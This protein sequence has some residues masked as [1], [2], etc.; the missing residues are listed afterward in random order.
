M[1]LPSLNVD[2]KVAFVTGTGSG[3]GRAISIGL[4]QAG[5]DLALTELPDRLDAARETAREIEKLGKRAHVVP[6]DVMK[7]SQIG[8]SVDA[9]LKHFGHLD[10]LVNNAGVNIPKLAVDV[11][12]ADW[13]K[14]MAIDLKGVFFTTQTVAKKALIPQG[15]GKVVNIASQMGV[16]GYK[17]RAAYCSAKAGVVNLSRV[18]AF[19]WAKHKITVN[20]VAP[21]FI[22]TPLTRPMFE[23]KEFY[24]DVI[25][26]I[27]MGR[28][29]TPED[30]VGAV[31]YLSSPAADMVTGHTLLVDG[32][33]TAV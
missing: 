32:G 2:G 31:V 21:T 17:Y 24:N 10:I 18:L 23:D 14:V 7:L 9:V 1:C 20:S 28:L 5:A 15:A 13:D 6:L 11:T 22:D 30:V 33:W 29:G 3:L 25:S 12:E 27:P 26:R 4:A 16:V 19:E 8:E